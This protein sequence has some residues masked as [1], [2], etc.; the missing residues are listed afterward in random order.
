[1]KKPKPA[2]VPDTIK[3]SDALYSMWAALE[4]APEQLATRLREGKAS[5]AEMALAADLIEKIVTP[6]RPRKPGSSRFDKLVILERVAFL[7][8]LFP[9]WQRK[10]II[11]ETAHQLKKWNGWDVSKTHIYNVLTE[12]G[13][14]GVGR[15]GRMPKNEDELPTEPDPRLREILKDV[16]RDI[17]IELIERFF[18]R[19]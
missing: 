15:I 1:V 10:K 2:L 9:T 7:E 17:L 18:P 14:D 5:K 16:N 4:T 11:G 8:K 19:K 12:F 6:Q 3:T 13:V